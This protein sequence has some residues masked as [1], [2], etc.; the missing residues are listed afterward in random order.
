MLLYFPLYHIWLTLKYNQIKTWRRKGAARERWNWR[1]S[2]MKEFISLLIVVHFI[3]TSINPP[4][5]PSNYL[6]WSS[7]NGLVYPTKETATIFLS[8]YKT[9]RERNLIQ[10]RERNKF[11][12]IS[13]DLHHFHKLWISS[14]DSSQSMMS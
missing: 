9:E 5:K 7:T 12:T 14:L 4:Q 8:L 3:F 11:P 13:N 6:S 10:N 2:W 1:N